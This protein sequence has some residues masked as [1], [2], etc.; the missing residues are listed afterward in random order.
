MTRL[1]LDYQPNTSSKILGQNLSIDS[2]LLVIWF[3]KLGP[4]KTGQGNDI[5]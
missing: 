2:L 5:N 3:Q 4:Y 1:G